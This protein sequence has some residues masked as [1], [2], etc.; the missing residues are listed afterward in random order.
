[1]ISGH[2]G[3][4]SLTRRLLALGAGLAGGKVLDLGAGK[5][6]S[7]TWLCSHGY[8]AVGIDLIPAE[9][10]VMKQDMRRLQYLDASFEYC[11]AECSVSVCGDGMEAL[12]EACR[13][14]RP[15]GRLLLSDVFFQREHAPRLSF[16]HPLTR[17]TWEKSF[18]EAGFV[19]QAFE[20]ETVLWKEFFI[21][22]LWNGNAEEECS[23]FFRHAGKYGCG[24]FLAVLEKEEILYGF[25]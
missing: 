8:E 5:G 13:V 6:E 15:G 23:G 16:E 24:Y 2:P 12:K 1:M 18:R 11:L 17:E 20:D 22:S 7:V 4:I 3:G 10:L 25:V 19:L 14:L 21:E 9:P